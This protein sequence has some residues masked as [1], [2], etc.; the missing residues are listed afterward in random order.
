VPVSPV[1]EELQHAI[2]RR[3]DESTGEQKPEEW[4]LL[5]VLD[6]I[7]KLMS[8]SLSA[9][10]LRRLRITAYGAMVAYGPAGAALP[11]RPDP[12]VI[13]VGLVPGNRARIRWCDADNDVDA[14]VPISMLSVRR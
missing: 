12:L 14:G 6:D 2:L 11:T 13:D 9:L 8:G 1:A 3:V 4:V 5:D 10:S 7:D